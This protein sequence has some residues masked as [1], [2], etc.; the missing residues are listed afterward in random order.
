MDCSNYSVLVVDDMP[1]NVE[2]IVKMIKPY[3]FDVRTARGGV[4]ALDSVA[5]KKPD[6]ILLDGMMPD[7][8]GLEVLKRLR[9]N[10]TT[11]SIRVIMVSARVSD[12]DV[13]AA[14]QAGADDYI[15]KPIILERLH[16]C[17]NK[18]IAAI[19]ANPTPCSM[20]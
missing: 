2:L 11:R 7:L 13:S 20:A 9:S 16:A 8:D 19:Q 4:D 5:S 6:I 17:I 12:A 18:N 10:E 1:L 15:V 3:K 14:F